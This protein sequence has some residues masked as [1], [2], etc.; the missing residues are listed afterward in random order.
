[1][2]LIVALRGVAVAATAISPETT[3]TF[4]R[5]DSCGTAGGSA[6]GPA[7]ALRGSRIWRSVARRRP[8]LDS[9]IGRHRS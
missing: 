3:S 5:S 4:S 8:G 1:M 2:Q 6:S 7:L 9:V